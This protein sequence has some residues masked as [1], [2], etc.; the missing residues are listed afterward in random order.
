M[1]IL[2]RRR[3]ERLCIGEQVVI[4]ILDV[5]GHQVRVG[6]E[7]PKDVPVDREEVH[8]RKDAERRRRLSG[9]GGNGEDDAVR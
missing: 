4:T 6:I 1:L 8:L 7:A 3:G 2:T 5:R 9:S